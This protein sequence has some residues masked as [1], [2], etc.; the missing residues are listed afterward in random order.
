MHKKADVPS[1]YLAHTKKK[2]GSGMA[3]DDDMCGTHIVAQDKLLF[4]IHN[5]SKRLRN[6]HSFHNRRW[7][8][9]R[10]NY[11]PFREDSACSLI[12]EAVGTTRRYSIMQA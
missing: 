1:S 10:L 4:A 5:S 7:E 3:Q 11:C 2:N 8:K 9:V 6:E 12:R